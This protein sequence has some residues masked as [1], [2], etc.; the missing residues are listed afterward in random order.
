MLVA[1]GTIDDF[2]LTSCLLLLVDVPQFVPILILVLD[3]RVSENP[4]PALTYPFNAPL[5]S[6]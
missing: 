4:I 3:S 6:H 2:G 5:F 1:A